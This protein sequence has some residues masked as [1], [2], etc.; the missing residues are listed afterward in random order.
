MFCKPA[1]ANFAT[2]VSGVYW[3]ESSFSRGKPR[4]AKG[5]MMLILFP[6]N[7]SFLSARSPPNASDFMIGK[8]FFVKDKCSTVGGICFTGISRKPPVLHSTWMCQREKRAIIQPQSQLI[9]FYCREK[10]FPPTTQLCKFHVMP[11]SWNICSRISTVKTT[12]LWNYLEIYSFNYIMLLIFI[13][14]LFSHVW[15]LFSQLFFNKSFSSHFNLV[16]LLHHAEFLIKFHFQ[17]MK[18]F[19]MGKIEFFLFFFEFH[20][21]FHFARLKSEESKRK[22]IHPFMKSSLIKLTSQLIAFPSSSSHNP[23]MRSF[24]LLS[25]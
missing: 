17:E 18:Y 20:F 16:I 10:K 8:L 11:L 13:L 23:P 19:E 5:L 21:H 7:T 2:V 1:N 4:N 6:S 12:W 24:H 22:I 15:V 9:E 25:W 14:L 3:I